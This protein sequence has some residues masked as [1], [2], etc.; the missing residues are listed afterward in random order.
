MGL[1]GDGGVSRIDS[2]VYVLRN[3]LPAAAVLIRRDGRVV[4][5]GDGTDAGVRDALTTWLGSR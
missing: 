1:R 5:V 3:R 4:W 2:Q